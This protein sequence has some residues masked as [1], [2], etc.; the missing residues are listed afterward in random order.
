[1]YEQDILMTKFWQNDSNVWD[2]G[3]KE[4][5]LVIKDNSGESGYAHKR[6]DH[7][8][9]FPTKV[10]MTVTHVSADSKY[11]PCMVSNLPQTKS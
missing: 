5:H 9:F 3:I 1:V 2:Q 7:E 4:V 6:Q 11:A 8:K 10:H